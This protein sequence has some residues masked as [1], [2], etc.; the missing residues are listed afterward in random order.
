MRTD[1]E[2]KKDVIHEL[3]WESRYNALDVEVEVKNGSVTL[4]G[5]VDAYSKKI[6]AER[7]ALRVAGIIWVNNNIEVRIVDKKS[8]EEIQRAAINAIRWNTTIDEDEIDVSVKN[9]WITLE[10]TVAWEY[11]KS[12][13]RNLAEDVIGVVGVTNLISVWTSAGEIRK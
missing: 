5:T 11:Q 2:I 12:K 6:E 13:A 10:G 1:V 4:S 3:E 8:D 9:G 7:A